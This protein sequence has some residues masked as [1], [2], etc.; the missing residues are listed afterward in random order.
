MTKS[1]EHPRDRGAVLVTVALVLLLLLGFAALA[2]DASM[3]YNEHR[4]TQGAADNAALAGAWAM[5]NGEDPEAAALASATT[6][7]YPTGVDVSAED[8]LVTVTISAEV[9]TGFGRTQGV[10]QI[11]VSSSATA[12]CVPGT[13]GGALGKDAALISTGSS[14]SETKVLNNIEVTGIVYSASGLTIENNTQ[15]TGPVYAEGD[16]VVENNAVVNGPVH[17]NGS[18]T[19]KNNAEHN[20]NSNATYVGSLERKNNTSTWNPLKVTARERLELPAPFDAADFAPGGAKAMSAGA[21]YRHIVGDWELGNNETIESGLYYVEGNVTVK[22]NVTGTNVTIVATGR[23]DIKNNAEFSGTFVDGLALMSTAGGGSCTTT[24]IDVSNNAR[25]EGTV[26]APNG[27]VYMGN[28]GALEGA[29]IGLRV[30][31][32]NNFDILG[33]EMPW[34]GGKPEVVL[35]S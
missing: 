4:H 16:L 2:V 23:I 22:N 31:L 29:V 26:Y 10:S 7:G 25:V 1:T 19:I 21:K 34:G 17:T 11:G 33:G 14:C 30:S 18:L 27:H 5:C 28:N 13:S 24:A 20:H 32:K 12:K 35:V 9:T 3:G 15:V 8:D 6:N